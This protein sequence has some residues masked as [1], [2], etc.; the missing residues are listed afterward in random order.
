[1]KTPSFQDKSCL[2]AACFNHPSSVTFCAAASSKSLPSLQFLFFSFF[3]SQH[4]CFSLICAFL[5]I[6]SLSSLWLPYATTPISSSLQS[7][8]LSCSSVVLLPGEDQ[9][10]EDGAV[11]N[12]GHEDLQANGSKVRTL[13][14]CKA[15][16]LNAHW[17]LV[18]QLNEQSELNDACT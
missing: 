4:V 15:K 6:Y 2:F 7:P 14:L 9:L 13:F 17:C 12:G 3:I 1:M 10:L 11:H 18:Q 8:C 16:T 5:F